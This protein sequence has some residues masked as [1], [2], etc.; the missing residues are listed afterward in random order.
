M[1]FIPSFD[2]PLEVAETALWFVFLKQKLL[3]KTEDENYSFPESPDL[4]VLKLSPVKR[5]YLGLLDG[6]P[7]YAAELPDSKPISGA[8]S[9]MGIRSIFTQLEEDVLQ[10]AGLAN[11]L[12]HWNQNHQ[13][14]GKCGNPTENKTDER[15]KIC[16]QCGSIYYPRLSPAIIVA[17]INDNRI[18]L[19]HSQ[20]FPVKFYSVLAGF[21]EPG[22]TLEECVK[23]EVREEVGIAVENIRYFGSQP[24]PFPDSLMIAFTA[25]YAGGEIRIDNSEIVDAGWFSPDELPSIP[26]KISIA[27]HLIDWFL[28]RVRACP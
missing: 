25:E 15:A 3:I 1:P 4:E 19:A 20:R 26:P 28:E 23:R 17:V 21:V 13:Y 8:Y 12:V 2:P 18:L 14:C 7:C 11:Q 9:F 6:R 22:E 16:T 10:A 24:W 27:R 5:Q